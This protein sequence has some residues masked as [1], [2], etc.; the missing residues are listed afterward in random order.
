MTD[1]DISLDPEHNVS[2]FM[3][4]NNKEGYRLNSRPLIC[5]S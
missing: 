3:K 2:E 4:I 5:S 1:Q